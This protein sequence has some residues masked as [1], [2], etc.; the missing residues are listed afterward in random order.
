MWRLARTGSMV[1][2]RDCRWPG[3]DSREE[4]VQTHARCGDILKDEEW[5]EEQCFVY[6]VVTCG[7]V[8]AQAKVY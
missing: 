6:A 3:E 1:T 4:Q 2:D 5:P 8:G 7:Y